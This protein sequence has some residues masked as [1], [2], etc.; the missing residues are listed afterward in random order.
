MRLKFYMKEIHQL[1][2]PGIG[3]NDISIQMERNKELHLSGKDKRII[4][5]ECSQILNVYKQANT[6]LFRGMHSK[7]DFIK[8]TP[9]T[10]RIPKDMDND[11]HE[12]I[13]EY[14]KKHF[15]WGGRSEGV[16][17]SSRFSTAGGYGD[18]V[19]IIFPSNGFK[20]LWSDEVE[21]LYSHLNDYYEGGK[22]EEWQRKYGPDSGNG[23]W[24]NVDDI[25]KRIDDLE[26]LEGHTGIDVEGDYNDGP[27]WYADVGFEDDYGN[28]KENEKWEWEPKVSFYEYEGSLVNILETYTA[29]NIKQAIRTGHEIMIKCNYYYAL[30][31][32]NQWTKDMNVIKPEDFEWK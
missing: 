10:D 21:D 24:F 20:F 4:E 31:L 19:Y 18:S 5:K 25:K 22:E 15:G 8:K 28:Q 27:Y 11:N 7:D 30:R 13:D 1:G 17:C 32:T 23:H 12:E 26:D 2:L 9:R 6:F 3:D 14:F 29:T 16:F